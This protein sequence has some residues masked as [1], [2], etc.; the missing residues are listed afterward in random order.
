V[1]HWHLVR[2]ANLMVTKVRQRV[3]HETKGHRGRKDDLA[4][5]HRMLLLRAG[6]KLSE[7]A[8]H[9]LDRVFATTTRPGR[10]V[11]PGA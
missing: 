7:R 8:V 5:A 10:S 4:W 9:R 3:A 1:D 6:D 11:P 2:L